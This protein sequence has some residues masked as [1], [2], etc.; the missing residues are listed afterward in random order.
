MTDYRK[1]KHDRRAGEDHEW[2]LFDTPFLH[3][4][5]TVKRHLASV[6][7]LEKELKACS[8]HKTVVVTHHAPHPQSIPSH[9]QNN[10]LA[11]A[12]ASN[13]D[14]LMGQCT[15]W[16]HGHIHHS[17]EYKVRGTR[18]IANPRGY[19]NVQGEGCNPGFDPFFMVE[20]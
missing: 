7:W 9:Q 13:L 12:Y 4:E 5:A 15:L 10:A 11:P 20:V 6:E 18:V 2:Q 1:I 14:D 8:F 19:A 3:P 16:I 17:A